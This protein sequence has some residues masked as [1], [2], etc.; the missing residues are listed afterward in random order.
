[1]TDERCIDCGL[2]V[3]D[4]QCTSD[5]PECGKAYEE[6]D[7]GDSVHEADLARLDNARDVRGETREQRDERRAGA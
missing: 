3:F 2:H 7:C 1:M 5:C 4:C 6:C